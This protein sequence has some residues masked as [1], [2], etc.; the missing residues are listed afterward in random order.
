MFNNL[1][2]YTLQAR[3]SPVLIVAFPLVLWIA[4]LFPGEA[5]GLGLLTG[6]LSFS[7][8]G[9]LI[10]QFGRDNGLKKQKKLFAAW[11]DKPTTRFFRHR[12]SKF[13]PVMLTALHRNMHHLIDGTPEVTPEE[14]QKDPAGADN[15]YDRWTIFLKEATRDTGKFPLVHAENI[16]YGFRRNLYGLKWLGVCAALWPLL[17]FGWSL[18][19]IQPEGFPSAMDKATLT[20][21]LLALAYYLKVVSPDWVK[22]VAEAYAERLLLASDKLAKENGKT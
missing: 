1:D 7:G 2:T 10:G 3:V 9:P 15:T 6:L 21:S 22:T 13:S 16:N 18:Q 8:L 19:G 4:S 11:G 20:V 17:A 12:D 14:E 5:S